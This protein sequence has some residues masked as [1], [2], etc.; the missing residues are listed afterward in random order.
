MSR[1][2]HKVMFRIGG[3]DELLDP[4]PAVPAPALP[5]DRSPTKLASDEQPPTACHADDAPGAGVR[6]VSGVS[7]QPTGSL[8]ADSTEAFDLP[9]RERPVRPAEASPAAPMS[10]ISTSGIRVPIA[11][12]S[13]GA[14][15]HRRGH[16]NRE[17]RS[18]APPIHQRRPRPTGV[19]GWI[20]WLNALILTVL[21]VAAV[22]GH[23]PSSMPATGHR[24]STTQT[25]ANSSEPTRAPSDLPPVPSVHERR[26][27]SKHPVRAHPNTKV[28]G[29]D[30]SVEFV[31]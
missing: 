5:T 31:P 22:I 16:A 13:R 25:T 17:D 12:R 7:E 2:A 14:Q 23:D 21:I 10:S 27:P 9:T 20:T 4:P 15:R 26:R 30:P 11:L 8:A 1:R 18:I 28:A 29:G 6:V 24:S 19:H 3:E